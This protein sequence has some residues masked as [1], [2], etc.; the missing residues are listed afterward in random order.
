MWINISAAMYTLIV[1]IYS[2]KEKLERERII[3]STLRLESFQ[4]VLN[5]AFRNLLKNNF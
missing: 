2:F 3:T 1:E 5:K 4:G